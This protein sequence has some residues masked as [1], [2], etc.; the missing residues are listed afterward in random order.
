MVFFLM[1]RGQKL[2]SARKTKLTES[3]R[4]QNLKNEKKNK[5]AVTC[6]VHLLGLLLS[7][8]SLLLDLLLFVYGD[9]RVSLSVCLS[10]SGYLLFTAHFMVCSSCFIQLWMQTKAQTDYME[11]MHN[12]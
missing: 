7:H 9:V 10:L 6:G 12:R 8:F 5:K 11:S 2:H 1:L 3:S 4:K